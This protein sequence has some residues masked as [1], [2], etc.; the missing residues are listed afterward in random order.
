MRMMNP[1]QIIKQIREKKAQIIRDTTQKEIEFK[2]FHALALRFA[3]SKGLGELAEDFAQEACIK[4]LEKGLEPTLSWLLIDF[5]RMTF[6]STRYLKS[7]QKIRQ[8]LNLWTEELKDYGKNQPQTVSEEN[9]R[10]YFPENLLTERETFILECLMQGMQI[11]EIAR[12]LKLHPSQV[13]ITI[14]QDIRTK[15]L[16]YRK[17]ILK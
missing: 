9:W 16:P 6:G 3:K 14:N 5:L 13:S 10:E 11:K 4:Y 12:I 8:N 17:D 1:E 15:L 7:G 2:R